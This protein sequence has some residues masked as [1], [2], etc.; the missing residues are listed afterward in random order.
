MT[1]SRML[2][3]TRAAPTLVADMLA[4]NAALFAEIGNRLRRLD[5]AVATTCA[6]GS[7]DHAAGYFKYLVEITHGLPVASIGPS[8]ASIYR[9]PLRLRGS[10]MLSISQSGRSPDIIALQAA[11][12]AAGALTISLCNTPGSPLSQAA[13]FDVPLLAGPEISV[14]ATKSFI[15]SCAAVVAIVAAWTSDPALDSALKRLPDTLQ[16][17]LQVDWSAADACLAHPSLYVIGRGAALPIALEAAL[18]L[19]ETAALHA[20]GFSVAE[21]MHGPLQLAGPGFPVLAFVPDDAALPST[22]EALGRIAA[23]GAVLLTIG[24]S[25]L[26]GVHLP[27]IQT[28]HGLTDPIAMIQAFYVLAERIARARGLDPDR[29]SRLSKVTQTT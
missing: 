20:E 13:D 8:I 11:A 9:T 4:S 19:K 7:S 23:T 16:Q 27:T 5:P 18:K 12:K 1:P 29:P 6:R 26:P 25:T 22:R 24:H 2:E 28:G 14:A 17:A 10:L 15:L 3:E 21:V